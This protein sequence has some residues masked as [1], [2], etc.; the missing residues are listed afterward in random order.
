MRRHLLAA[1]LSL[2]LALLLGTAGVA[3][4]Y[5]GKDVSAERIGGRLGLTDQNGR[6][7][8]LEEFR[9][10]VVLIYFGYTRCPDVCPTTLIRMA[11]VMKLLGANAV[12]AQVLWVTVDPERDTQELLRNYV[13]AFD[14]SF[15]AL[16]GT[17]AETDGLTK[18]FG[19]NY[20]IMKYKGA[21]LVDHSTFGY[22][23]DAGGKT[24]LRLPYAMTAEQ[25]AADVGAF[26][27]KD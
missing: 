18:A 5:I 21:I 20:Q 10:K 15:L 25:I 8:N 3:T 9:G 24:R 19:I 6:R 17:P 26:L 11:Q 2:V 13:P 22:L 12:K 16:R 14:A 7:R 27:R 4:A 23:I 1:G